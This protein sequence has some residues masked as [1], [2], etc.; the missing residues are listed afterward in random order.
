M[1][2]TGYSGYILFF[3]DKTITLTQGMGVIEVFVWWQS[4]HRNQVWSRTLF[5]LNTIA[6]R[7]FNY[8]ILTWCDSIVNQYK[9]GDHLNYTHI[10]EYILIAMEL[11]PL[12]AINKILG[13]RMRLI[14]LIE[15]D[16]FAGVINKFWE[17][18]LLPGH[19]RSWLIPG[20]F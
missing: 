6:D 19:L 13:T 10:C 5:S 17:V 11:I 8:L 1:S 15:R 12:A 4:E 3:L 16:Y 9:R 14:F 7:L 2:Q 18:I 20:L